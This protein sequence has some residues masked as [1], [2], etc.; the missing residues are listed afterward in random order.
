MPPYGE[1]SHLH[2]QGFYA[3]IWR[4][5]TPT[6]PYEGVLRLRMEGFY[7]FVWR[8]STPP[9]GGELCLHIEGYLEA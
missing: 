2:I 8:G 7:A 4:G 9:Y 5:S 1:E 6:P 3:S